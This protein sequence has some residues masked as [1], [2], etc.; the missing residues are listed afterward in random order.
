MQRLGTPRIGAY[1]RASAGPY[2]AA[3]LQNAKARNNVRVS[4]AVAADRT[5]VRHSTKAAMYSRVP[6]A[7]V[8]LTPSHT[9]RPHLRWARLKSPGSVRSKRRQ[10]RTTRVT[11]VIQVV[12]AMTR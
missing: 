9:R 4:E 10:D 12:T 2:A 1:R 6:V 11:Q 3:A 7:A 8:A 5:G